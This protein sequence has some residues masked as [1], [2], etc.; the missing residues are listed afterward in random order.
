MIEAIIWYIFLLDSIVAN[1]MVWFNPKFFKK[2][3]YKPFF[4]LFP[5]TKGWCALYLG[6]VLWVGYALLRLN[7]LWL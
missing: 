4:K 7:V 1:I 2:G 6:L 5:V 3:F